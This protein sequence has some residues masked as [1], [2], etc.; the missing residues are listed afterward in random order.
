MRILLLGGSGLVGKRT[1]QRLTQDHA[2]D[3]PNKKQIDLGNLESIRLIPNSYEVV[4]HCA[5]VRNYSI[6]TLNKREIQ[7]MNMVNG[8]YLESLLARCTK[9]KSVIYL[10]SGGL[11]KPSQQLLSEES[12]LE[13]LSS[14]ATHF[15]GKLLAE[16]FLS[17]LTESINVC[18]L[19]LFTVFGKEANL[20]SL[21]PRI[22]QKIVEGEAINLSGS[23]GD[24]L[25]PTHVDDVVSCISALLEHDLNG[26]FNLGGPEIITFRTLVSRLANSIGLKPHFTEINQ[27]QKVLAPDNLAMEAYLYIP[28]KPFDGNWEV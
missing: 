27:A 12:A 25:R 13:D 14:L 8:G 18:V 11:Y 3:I 17:T 20:N 5:Q 10:S 4:I 2:I 19:R 6:E 22:H 7:Q 23:D 15:K 16:Q 9:V 26:T 21:M 28:K 24:L 1:Y